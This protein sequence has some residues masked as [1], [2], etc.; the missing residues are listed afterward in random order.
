MVGFSEDCEGV[1]LRANEHVTCQYSDS[2]DGVGR[3]HA[4]GHSSCLVYDFTWVKGGRGWVR[5]E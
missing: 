1:Q 5:G 2:D 4:A 3:G